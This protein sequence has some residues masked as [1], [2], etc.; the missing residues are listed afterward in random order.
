[1]VSTKNLYAASVGFSINPGIDDL[2]III[3]SGDLGPRGDYYKVLN[4]NGC[5][6]YSTVAYSVN[7]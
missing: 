2:H 7:L 4:S 3:A 1:M 6:L 5:D